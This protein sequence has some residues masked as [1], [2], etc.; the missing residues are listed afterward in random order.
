[1]GINGISVDKDG[2]LYTALYS[3]DTKGS[4]NLA[5]LK[6]DNATNTYNVDKV[7]NNSPFIE[8]LK[9]KNNT[10]F[11]QHDDYYILSTV[12][13]D[14]V[15]NLYA[16]KLV[17]YTISITDTNNFIWFNVDKE[18]G[19]YYYVHDGKECILTLAPSKPDTPS[20]A[21]TLAQKTSADTTEKAKLP[22][23]GSAFDTNILLLCGVIFVG[24]GIVFVLERR[25]KLN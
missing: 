5:R 1:M 2:N 25:K 7:I 13:G 21:Q 3:G 23:T 9:T 6:L 11:I 20:E 4:F 17:N 10:Y 24:I 22:Q 8:L 14:K 15:V 12:N 19:K 18:G 16:N